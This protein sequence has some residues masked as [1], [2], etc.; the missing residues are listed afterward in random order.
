MAHTNVHR[1]KYHTSW[2]GVHVNKFLLIFNKC[3]YFPQQYVFFIDTQSSY[4]LEKGE[5]ISYSLGAISV[6]SKTSH[7]LGTCTLI[8]LLL[9]IPHIDTDYLAP[10]W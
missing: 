6:L 5:Q 7:S 2:H 3:N 10:R 8:N 1:R 9:S 4:S